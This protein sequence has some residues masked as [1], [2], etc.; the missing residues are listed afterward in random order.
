MEVLVIG[1]WPKHCIA[2]GQY[3]VVLLRTEE[4]DQ[5]TKVCNFFKIHR[6]VISVALIK[7]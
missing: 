7:L 5:K 6:S 3:L 4:S 2:I 1:S